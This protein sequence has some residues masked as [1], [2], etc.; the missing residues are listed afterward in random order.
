MIEISQAD[1]GVMIE[2]LFD[3][4]NIR[5]DMLCSIAYKTLHSTVEHWCVNDP[6]L[7][8]MKYEDDIMQEIYIRLIKT[9]KSSFLLRNGAGGEINNDPKGFKNWLFKVALNIKRDFSKA[10]R[11]RS[12][13]ETGLVD[14]EKDSAPGDDGTL[15]VDPSEKCELLKNAVEIVLNSDSSVYKVLTWLAQC[16]F[17]VQFDVTKIQSNSMIIDFFETKTLHEMYNMILD[18]SKDIPWLVISAKQQQK[19]EAKL[20]EP[21][22]DD[23]YCGQVK[24][25]E[26]FMKKGGKATI[27]DWVNRTNNLIKRVVRDG[28]SDS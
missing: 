18:A 1:F 23:R 28:S 4:N 26:F 9:C 5:F 19:I 14:G 7:C 21:W 24:F 6:Y 12:L 11:R 17:V 8:G 22:T 2:Q 27:S 15:P 20:N 25:N 10:V 3:E 16:L 13:K